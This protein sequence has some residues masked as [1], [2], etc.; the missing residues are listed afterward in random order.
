MLEELLTLARLNEGR[1]F[2]TYDYLA[3]ATSLGRMTVARAL[4]VLDQIG[5]IVRQRRFKRVE[6][7]GPGPRYEQT[8][9]AYR[10]LLP[11]ALLAYLPRRMRPAPLPDDE[12]QR[13][14]D[15]VED[16]RVMLSQLDC[17]ALAKASLADG[18]LAKVLAKLGAAIDR[19]ECEYHNDPQPLL[20]S[21]NYSAERV[22]LDGQ[23]IRPD[24]QRPM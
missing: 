8:S 11:Q 1:V 18:P 14:A 10:A 4:R 6:A 2:P 16:H 24:G 7:K 13:Q 23:Q 15:R 21:F 5:F 12:L 17:Q 22:G 3:K 20:E 19:R 9:N